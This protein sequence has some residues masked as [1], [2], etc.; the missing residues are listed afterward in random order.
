M[1]TN[2]LLSQVC[3]QNEFIITHNRNIIN[4]KYFYSIFSL[5]IDLIVPLRPEGKPRQT[6]NRTPFAQSIDIGID[7]DLCKCCKQHINIIIINEIC[8]HYICSTKVFRHSIS[9]R[10]SIRYLLRTR[11]ACSQIYIKYKPKM[12]LFSFLDG[13]GFL[14]RTTLNQSTIQWALELDA[15]CLVPIR[16][17]RK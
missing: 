9:S 13:V 10:I 7:I 4:R 3:E 11:F 8:V 12:L 6:H 17:M 5:W 15:F 16:K 1:R 2:P 14:F